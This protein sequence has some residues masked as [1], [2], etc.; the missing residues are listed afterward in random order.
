MRLALAHLAK[1]ES[2]REL[3]QALRPL[4]Q[5]ARERG[6]GLLLLPEL[7][8]GKRED[9]GLPQALRELAEEAGLLLLAG[10]LAEGKNRLQAFPQGPT[11]AKLHLYRAAGEE[12]DE[13]LRPGEAPGLWT[14]EGRTVGLGLCYDLDFPELFR[15]YAL[16][17]AA[18]FLVGAA[19]PGAYAGLLEV[20]ARARAAENQAYLFLASR[21][22]TGSPSLFVAPDGQVL[23]RREEEGLLIAEP[24]W[25][26]L[27]AY[28][29]KYPLLRHR[30]EDLYR[31]W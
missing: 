14:W 28:R 19:W 7:V 8:L 9:P 20:L 29:K 3:L 16:R 4:A 25:G 15:L 30:R 1:R 24:D 10:H 6:A 13:G 12:G 22:D 17:G 11:Y 27:E 21:A 18:G 2:L 26:F 23:G 31:L 5:E